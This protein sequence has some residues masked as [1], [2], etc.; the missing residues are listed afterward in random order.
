MTKPAEAPSRDEPNESPPIRHERFVW[1]G[2]G[3][4]IT[5]PKAKAKTKPKDAAGLK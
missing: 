3:G 1:D 2:E 4:T 5:P